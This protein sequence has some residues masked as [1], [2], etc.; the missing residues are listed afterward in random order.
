MKKSLLALSLALTSIPV[1]AANYSIDT[2][3][4]AMGGA[5]TAAA[6][7]LSAGFHN[8]A[9]VAMDPDSNF[10]VLFPVIG[11]QLRDPDELVD[12]LEDFGGVFDAFKAEPLSETNRTNAANA[13]RNLQNKL[14]YVSGGIGGAIALPTSTISGNFFVKGYT[15]AVVIPE[16]SDTDISNIESPVLDPNAD[17]SLTS[18][19]RVLAFGVVDVGLA[20]AGNI[21]L[22]GQRIAIGVTPK[23][24][25]YYTYH[26]EVSVENF[27]AND[28]DSDANRTEDS[29]FNID[30]G[31]AWQTGPFRVGF[32]A[33]N[34]ISQDIKTVNYT[35]EYTYHID[36]LYTVGGAFITDLFV[37][38]IDIDFNKQ[39]RFSAPSGPAIIDDTQLVRLG[40]EFNAWG[41]AQVRAGYIN[42][43]EDTLDGIVTLGLGLSPFDTVHFDLAA[44]LIDSNSYG[45]SAQLSFTF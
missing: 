35:R 18:S 34:M 30:L 43:L 29:A 23:S 13:L 42:D 14:A 45:G 27:E 39:K 3:I 24:Q 37:A 1:L 20:L 33:K 40:A 38:A 22:A 21:E 10:G 41:W 16:I 36:P 2:R 26:Y 31:A 32:A 4:D 44:Q 7:Y 6:D 25:K 12:K 9:L 8:P 15:E 5:G 28:W 17:Y 19:G 11:I